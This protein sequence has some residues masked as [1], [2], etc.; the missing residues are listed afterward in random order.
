MSDMTRRGFLKLLGLATASIAVQAD[1]ILSAAARLAE[2]STTMVM[3]YLVYHKKRKQYEVRATKYVDL[4][5]TSLHPDYYDAESFRVLEI[6]ENQEATK[7]RKELW[8]QHTDARF[9]G[10]KV[11]IEWS[12]RNGKAVGKAAAKN[13]HAKKYSKIIAEGKKK[14]AFYKKVNREK[15]LKAQKIAQTHPNKIAAAKRN[16]MLAGPKSIEVQQ[17]RSNERVDNL[18][19]HINVPYFG[20]KELTVAA[21]EIGMTVAWVKSYVLT[22]TK[23]TKVKRGV[24]QKV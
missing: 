2:Q 12:T 15:M 22:S 1:P 16:I 13:E 10:G 8:Y 18:L 21:G 5:S 19:K 23:I 7:R 11:N 9:W 3:L 6:V 14:S 24:Y 4:K 20:Y 17:K